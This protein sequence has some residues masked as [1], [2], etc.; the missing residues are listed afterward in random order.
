MLLNP[1]FDPATLGSYRYPPLAGRNPKKYLMNGIQMT[2]TVSFE[3][4]NIRIVRLFR[5]SNFVLRASLYENYIGK[6]LL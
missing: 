6:V 1:K 4:L 5:A 2:E 3:N